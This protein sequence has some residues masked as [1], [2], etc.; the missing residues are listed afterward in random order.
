[1]KVLADDFTWDV[2]YVLRMFLKCLSWVL[3]G[4][5]VV[6]LAGWISC[7]VYARYKEPSVIKAWEQATGSAPDVQSESLLEQYPK[8]ESNETAREMESFS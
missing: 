7:W 4:A 5:A 8:S 1:M 2:R 6:F 3:G